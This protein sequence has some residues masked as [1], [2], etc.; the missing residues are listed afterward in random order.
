MSGWNPLNN[1]QARFAADAIG[2]PHRV[3]VHL[4]AVH[5]WH[6]QQ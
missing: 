2:C 5:R 1:P 3:A 4:R 6:M